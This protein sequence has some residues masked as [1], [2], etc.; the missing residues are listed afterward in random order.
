[1]VCISA[2]LMFGIFFQDIPDDNI[3]ISG[4]QTVWANWDRTENGRCKGG[5]LA[6]LVNK[7][8]CNPGHV[9]IKEW[10][11]PDVE[12]LAVGLRPYYLLREFPH[13]ITVAIYMTSTMSVQSPFWVFFHFYTY[14]EPL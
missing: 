7:R 8:L 9:N 10:I 3:S 13:T 11:C 5:R 6:V 2:A 1:M 14:K 12:L 4:L